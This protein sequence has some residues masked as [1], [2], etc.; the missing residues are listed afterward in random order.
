MRSAD[1]RVLV[2][3]DSHTLGACNDAE[4]WPSL[5]EGALAATR[6]GKT[7]EVFNG[8]SDGY[9][10]FQYIG[11]LNGFSAFQPQ[12]FVAAVYGGNDFVEITG[13]WHHFNDTP[14]PPWKDPEAGQRKK[15][16]VRAE[17]EAMGQCF[18]ALF[19]FLHRPAQIEAM[20]LAAVDLCLEM[21]EICTR[22]GI[23]FAVLF[24]PSACDSTWS[25]PNR[26]IDSAV[27]ALDL[28]PEDL[29][30][31]ANMGDAFVAD[32]R[33]LGVELIDLRPVFSSRS[34]PP[35]WRQDLH[36]DLVGHRLAAEAVAPFLDEILP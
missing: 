24:I 26:A 15:R 25:E 17:P 3:G 16:A 11:T 1:V 6:P 23:G 12:A 36:L 14:F 9:S 35:F 4:T 33:E 20:R 8:A 10:F 29:D 21:Q 32:L 13:L 5:L 22:R 19:W 28:S 7:V 18:N 27:E 30:V 31:N 2:A 34:E